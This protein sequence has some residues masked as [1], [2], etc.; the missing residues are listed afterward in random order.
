VTL[1]GPEP[2]AAPPAARL[3]PDRR[4]TLRQRA[5]VEGGA[6]PLAL[7]LG[8]RIR[9]HEDEARACG[10]CRF[11]ELLMY[12]GATYPKCVLANPSRQ[13][14]VGRLTHGAATDVRR[15]WPAC[16]DHEYPAGDR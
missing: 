4:R 8:T 12:R 14:G 1:F 15:W 5:A 9:R 11:R 13:L 10:N 3:S 7:V 6:H 2:D 16:T